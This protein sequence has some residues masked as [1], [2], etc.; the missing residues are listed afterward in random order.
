MS[1][2]NIALMQATYQQGLNSN[3]FSSRAVDGNRDPDYSHASC[4]HSGTVM[5]P[6]WAVDLQWTR[7]IAT[8]NITNRVYKCKQI[9]FHVINECVVFGA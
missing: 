7:Q 3:G 8:V 6:W 5:H 2:D 9:L 1:A 4:T